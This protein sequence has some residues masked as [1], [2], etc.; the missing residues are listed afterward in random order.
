MEDI[1]MQFGLMYEIQVPEPHYDGIEQE[2]YKQ[3]MEQVELADEVGFTYFWT[4][5]HHFLRN[6]P[7]ARLQKSS[8]APSPN[9]PS[10]FASATPWPSYPVNITIRCGW[11]SAPPCSI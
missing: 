1:T 6:F 3:V 10:A 8:T 2:R 5:E 7:T 4:V 11:R 9:A